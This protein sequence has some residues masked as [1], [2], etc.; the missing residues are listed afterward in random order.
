MKPPMNVPNVSID[1]LFNK[2]FSTARGLKLEEYREITASIVAKVNVATENKDPA[3]NF[4][5]SFDKSTLVNIQSGNKYNN[6][7][8]LVSTEMTNSE[9]TNE[10]RTLPPR[11]TQMV[12]SSKINFNLLNIL[13]TYP[14]YGCYKTPMI[15]SSIN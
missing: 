5:I 2:K 14:Q 6:R 9:R 3:S 7:M 13:G 4:N 11:M 10:N 8:V 1:V 15:P 12:L